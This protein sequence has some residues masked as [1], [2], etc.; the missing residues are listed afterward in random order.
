MAVKFDTLKL[1]EGSA[2]EIPRNSTIMRCEYERLDIYTNPLQ[3]VTKLP[4]PE[5]GVTRQA[6]NLWENR[7]TPPPAKRLKQL[8]EF[9]GIDEKYFG[10]ISEEQQ[11]EID[12]IPAYRH[13]ENGHTYYCYVEHEGSVVFP[14]LS[15]LLNEKWL[16]ISRYG[17]GVS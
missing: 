10:E 12:A 1:H 5:A 3:C 7:T 4:C 6:I 14:G 13:E 9:F 17:V 8:T 15:T 16:G 2:C 11:H